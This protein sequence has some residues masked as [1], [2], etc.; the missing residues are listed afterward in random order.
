MERKY[1]VGLAHRSAGAEF[2]VAAAIV[3]RLTFGG[4]LIE[5]GT[6]S[7]RLTHEPT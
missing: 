4:N 6:E 2:G 1:G 3:D 7:Y 5:T